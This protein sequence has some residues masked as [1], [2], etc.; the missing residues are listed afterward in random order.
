MRPLPVT[1]WKAVVGLETGGA[2]SPSIKGSDGNVLSLGEKKAAG[3][4]LVPGQ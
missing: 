1:R 4:N 2:V 3:P